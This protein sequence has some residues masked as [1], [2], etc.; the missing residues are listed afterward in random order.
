MSALFPALAVVEL[1]PCQELAPFLP[2]RMFPLLLAL[3]P[4]RAAPPPRLLPSKPSSNARD[5][6]STW[7]A[8]PFLSLSLSALS[9]A[10]SHGRTSAPSSSAPLY[11]R[12]RRLPCFSPGKQ[13]LLQ[14]PMTPLP[15]SI[16]PCLRAATQCTV[17]ACYVLDKMC[18]KPRVIDSLQQLCPLPCVVIELRYCSSPMETS[19]PSVSRARLTT[20][21]HVVSQ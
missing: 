3:H 6:C 13:Q 21:T 18:S 2:G 5:G 15:S 1:T 19:S 12:R 8:A 4:W 9:A 7:S 17:G 20:L 11:C 14:L 16:P 10:G